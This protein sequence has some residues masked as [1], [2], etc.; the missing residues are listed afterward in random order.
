MRK[1]LPHFGQTF[2]FS[3]RSFFQMICRQLSHFTHSPSVRI[4]F[5]P[6]ESSSP[7]CRLNQA[8]GNR[9]WALG[10][11]LQETLRE[12]RSLEPEARGRLSILNSSLRHH[13]LFV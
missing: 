1:C 2:I 3:S 12:S 11:R 9:L 7:D 10:L 6:D 5:S 8:M 13:A 4:F